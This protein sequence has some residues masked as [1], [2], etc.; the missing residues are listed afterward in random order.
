MFN[1]NV[2]DVLW[3]RPSHV[4]NGPAW[5]VV[6]GAEHAPHGS[7]RAAVTRYR[8]SYQLSL[9]GHDCVHNPDNMRSV[10]LLR[11]QPGECAFNGVPCCQTGGRGEGD[12][13]VR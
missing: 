9:E 3:C 7:P 11:S 12:L 2:V 6:P 8:T 5:S 4:C 13:Y 10:F 1:L